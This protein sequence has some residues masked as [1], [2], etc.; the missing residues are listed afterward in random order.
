MA[1]ELL[2]EYDTTLDSKSRITVRAQS[3]KSLYKNYHVKIYNDG[4]IVLEPRVLVHPDQISKKTL[5]MMDLAVDN[6]AKGNR[7]E[8]VNIDEMRKLAD[9]LSD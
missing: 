1:A 9:G 2:K 5:K 6:Y 7:S 3:K 8:P 4:H